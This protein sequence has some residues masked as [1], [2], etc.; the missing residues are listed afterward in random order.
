MIS[1]IVFSVTY[2]C[3]V[4]CKFCVTESGPQNGPYLSAEFMKQVIRDTLELGALKSVIFTG[5]E[6]LMKKAELVETL[7]FAQSNGLWTRIVSNAF[8]ATSPDK[9][10]QL[11]TKLKQNG[12]NEINFS[13]DDLHQEMIPLDNVKHAFHAARNLGIPVLLAHKKVKNNLITPEFL[14]DYLGVELHQ[15][16]EEG[17]N[18]HRDM[19]S[20]GYTVPIG[21][22]AK[23]LDHSRYILYP[24]GCT[25]WQSPCSGVLSSII[26]SPGKELRICCGMIDQRVP[27]LS[28]G[29]LE[30]ERLA[31]IIC[32]GNQDLIANWL[33][34][35]G[36]YG[37]MKFVK[38]KAPHLE[39]ADRY[40]N[41]CH[42]CNELLTRSEVRDVLAHHAAEKAQGLSL[43]RGMLEALRF[44]EQSAANPAIS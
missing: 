44:H 1:K 4:S 6:A 16:N 26:I 12:L 21:L 8:W 11:L 32:R 15:F 28:I 18:P 41:H 9:A 39:F 5:G 37:V 31:E 29:N 36:P 40:V 22:Q 10:T 13:C 27:E 34:L 30:K 19:Y 35:E 43:Q 2:D 24:E 3:P 42:L 38:E 20:T 23:E 25:A 17:Q 7:E 14:A 33:A